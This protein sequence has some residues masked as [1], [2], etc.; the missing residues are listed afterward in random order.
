MKRGY[1]LMIIVILGIALMACGEKKTADVNWTEDEKEASRTPTVP[2]VTEAGTVGYVQKSE[3]KVETAKQKLET[4]Q[5]EAYIDLLREAIDINPKNQEALF[6]YA[7]ACLEGIGGTVNYRNA[8]YY[9]NQLL[10]TGFDGFGDWK[11]RFE[12]AKKSMGDFPDF[13]TYHPESEDGYPSWS[14][15]RWDG[16]DDILFIRLLVC[17]EIVERYCSEEFLEKWVPLDEKIR[18]RISKQDP[19]YYIQGHRNQDGTEVYKMEVTTEDSKFEFLITVQDP[20]GIIDI[21]WEEREL[22]K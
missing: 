12:E 6:L 9:Y 5:E 11:V 2:V 17:N 7:Q 16:E 21:T 3:Q 10:Q 15:L 13:L 1:G 20:E 19:R 4:G 22:S 18:E 8:V 14:Q